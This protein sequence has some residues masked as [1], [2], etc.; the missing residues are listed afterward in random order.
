ML[1]YDP[2][3]PW[4]K[5]WVPAEIGVTGLVLL[6]VALDLWVNGRGG[7]AFVF[8]VVGLCVLVPGV[9]AYARAYDDGSRF[10]LVL[11]V[12]LTIVPAAL[13]GFGLPALHRLLGIGR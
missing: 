8:L 9:R 13:A 11:W 3:V 2:S 12:L 5:A 7:L 1:G 4:W 6:I 10:S